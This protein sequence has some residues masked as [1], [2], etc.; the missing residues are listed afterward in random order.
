M[1]SSQLL[2][3]LA[4]WTSSTNAFY[5][6]RP[7]WLGDIE[8]KRALDSRGEAPTARSNG[9]GVTFDIKSRSSSQV[10]LCNV[11]RSCPRLTVTQS[12]TPFL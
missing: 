5:P 10:R 6:F 7:S 2:A 9:K 4:L 12:A 3:Q 1:R 8:K 11:P